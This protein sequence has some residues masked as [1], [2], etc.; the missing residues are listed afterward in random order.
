MILIDG[1]E[2]LA[3]DESFL[4]DRYGLTEREFQVASLLARRMTN[5]EIAEMVSISKH[6]ARH[7]T[8][9]ILSKLGLQSRREVADRL[10]GD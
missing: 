2:P 6:T 8:E 1:F 3:L 4:R 5:R 10:R 9:R 7:H